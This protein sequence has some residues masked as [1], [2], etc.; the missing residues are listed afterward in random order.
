MFR[1]VGL[2]LRRHTSPGSEG[3]GFVLGAGPWGEGCACHAISRVG[4]EPGPPLALSPGAPRRMGEARDGPGKASQG[5]SGLGCVSDPACFREEP[6]PLWAAGLEQGEAWD[7]CAPQGM[8]PG[9]TAG[10]D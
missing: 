3:P 4:L 2:L 1:E 7:H 9:Q 6:H 10:T 8:G 5:P